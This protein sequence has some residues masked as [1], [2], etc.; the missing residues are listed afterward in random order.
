MPRRLLGRNTRITLHGASQSGRATYMRKGDLAGAQLSEQVLA[1]RR[2]LLGPES[3]R[4]FS[5]RLESVRTLQTW[6]S[7]A[8]ARAVL[9]RDLLWLLDRDPATLGAD[10]RKIREYVARPSRITCQGKRRFPSGNES[11]GELNG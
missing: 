1:A 7:A 6:V 3:S 10:Q 9:E 5:L 11:S 8:A 2:R 4:H